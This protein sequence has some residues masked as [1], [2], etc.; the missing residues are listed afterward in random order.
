[1]EIKRDIIEKLKA[2]KE[3]PR[4]KPLV[5]QGARQVGKSWVLKKSSTVCT[6]SVLPRYTTPA[7]SKTEAIAA[8]MVEAMGS[9]RCAAPTRIEDRNV[10]FDWLLLSGI[11]VMF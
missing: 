7:L 9:M 6:F 3:N 2:W 8:W 10:S 1:M 11:V 5:L 4:R